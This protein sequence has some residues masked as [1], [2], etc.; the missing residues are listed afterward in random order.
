M[1]MNPVRYGLL[2]LA[3][4]YYANIQ[5][6]TVVRYYAAWMRSELPAEE[7]PFNYLTHIV[8]AFAWPE[9]DGSLS[10]Y[11]GFYYPQLIEQAH[12]TGKKILVSLGGAEQSYG[13]SSMASESSARS[14]FIDHILEFCTVYGYDGVDIDWEFP[15][16]S[17]DKNNLSLLVYNLRQKFINKNPELMITM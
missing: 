2:I 6:G 1:R 12:N 3:C 17:T 4:L 13:F 10:T 9:P 16:N 7:I 8:H 5:A 14:A 11:D 15:E